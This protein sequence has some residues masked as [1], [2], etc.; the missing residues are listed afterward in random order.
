MMKI[1]I[2]IAILLM[3]AMASCNKEI[4]NR[5]VINV[6]LHGYNISDMKLEVSVD[7]VVFDKQLQEAHKQVFFSMVYPYLPG[8]KEAVLSIKE[9]SGGKELL[10]KT[11]SL[12]E[13]QLEFYFN[14]V[15]IN[16]ELLEVA[17][18]AADSATNKLGFYI[19]YTEN[20]D[21]ID[22]ILYNPTNGAQAYLAQNVIPQT[23]IYTDYSPAQGFLGSNDV[24]GAI[25]Y[26]TKAGTFDWAFGGN[27]Y[28]SQASAF[29]WYLPYSLYNVGKVQPYF[30]KPSAEGGQAEVVKLFPTPRE[31]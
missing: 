18:P 31:Y 2:V 8:Q 21:P 28:M 14:L 3:F 9:Q 24:G 7:T 29:G 15:N 26:F 16:G 19:Y 12:S 5:K 13:G 30:I 23:W 17:P 6:T 20:N 25:V 22:I 27:E 4:E 1:N 10:R 11:L